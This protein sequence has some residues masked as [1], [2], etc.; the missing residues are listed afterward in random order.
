MRPARNGD[1]LV[2]CT[3]RARKLARQENKVMEAYEQEIRF[4]VMDGVSH[5]LIS[6]Y[7]S[8]KEPNRRGFSERSVRRFCSERDIHYRSRLTDAELDRRISTA[9]RSVGHSYGRRTLHGKAVA[10]TSGLVRPGSR[11]GQ[12]CRKWVWLVTCPV[13]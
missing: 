1:C 11:R 8:R 2:T 5:A 4:L 9:I 3:S 7:L 10:A 13:R 6:E 12:F